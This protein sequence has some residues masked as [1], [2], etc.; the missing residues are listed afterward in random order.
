MRKYSLRDTCGGLIETAILR[1]TKNWIFNAH[2]FVS[3]HLKRTVTV[4]IIVE[5][6][7]AINQNNVR[8]VCGRWI[9]GVPHLGIHLFRT[10]ICKRR[11]SISQD[12]KVT[13]IRW[14]DRKDVGINVIVLCDREWWNVVMN[15]SINYHLKFLLINFISKRY[16][17]LFF[18]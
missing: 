1:G 15:I 8:G 9:D 13:R 2:T 6:K 7:N 12:T 11:K 16:N 14:N 5:K 17:E 10:C 4:L 18:G 3:K